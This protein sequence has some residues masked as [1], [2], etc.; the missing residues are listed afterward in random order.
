VP[1]PAAPEAP[2][3]DL[4]ELDKAD[5]G[6]DVDV[7]VFN[8]DV[9]EGLVVDE[10]D[11]TLDA[12]QVDI[13]EQDA[14]GSSEAASEL[15]IGMTDLLDALPEPPPALEGDDLHEV[16]GELDRHLDAPLEADDPS[17]DAELGDDGLEALPELTRD[18]PDGDAGPELDRAILLGAPEGAIPRG[19]QLEAEWLSLGAPCFALSAAQNE[20]LAAGERLMRFAEQRHDLP[21]PSEARARSIA[22]LEGGAIAIATSRG[23]LELSSDGAITTLE[24]P[25][26]LRGANAD[27]RE[28]V[29][30]PRSGMLWARFEAGNLYTRR[31]RTWARHECG[32]KVASLSCTESTITLLVLGK[33]PTLQLSNDGGS[34]FSELLLPEPAATVALGSEPGA[35]AAGSTIALWDSERGLCVSSDG[36]ASFRMVTGAVNVTALAIGVRA[37]KPWLFAALYREARDL[38]ELIAVEPHSG[39]ACSVAELSAANEDDSEEMGRTW[40]L[41]C[42]NGRLWAAGSFGLVRLYEAA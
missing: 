9:S 39:A 26:G 30:A 13:Q 20:L 15:D 40:A 42:L 4:P 41:S 3:L 18:E 25:E 38:T 8:L 2:P 22:L 23:A 31:G 33:R 28:L 10:D 19:P 37:G 7:G 35:L 27:V 6:D 11:A 29:A 1:A 14:P 5:D 34:S 24:L 32:G 36:G 12:F 17:T 16:D 21:L